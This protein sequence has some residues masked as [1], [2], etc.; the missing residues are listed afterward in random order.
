MKKTILIVDDD[1]SVCKTTARLLSP[2]YSTVI[3]SSGREALDII[4]QKKRFDLVLMD[5]MMPEIDGLELLKKLRSHN[6]EMAV[7]MMSGYFTIDSAIDASNYGAHAYLTKPFDLEQLN[8]SIK[9]AL[10]E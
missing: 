1:F 4:N 7:I 3:A 2:T 6:K 8:K 10:H 5:M 9:S